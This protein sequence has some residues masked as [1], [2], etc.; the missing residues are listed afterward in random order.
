MPKSSCGSNRE[1]LSEPSPALMSAVP[2][3]QDRVCVQRPDHRTRFLYA[4]FGAVPELD[5]HAVWEEME[6]KIRRGFP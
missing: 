1:T 5:K 4:H 2:D 3:K 6:P